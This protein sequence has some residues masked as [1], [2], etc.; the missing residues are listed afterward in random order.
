MTTVK[1]LLTNHFRCPD[2]PIEFDRSIAPG[3]RAGYFQF[4]KG[5]TCYGQLDAA[6]SAEEVTEPLH[7][8]STD[9]RL[10][11]SGCTLPFDP[12]QV[13]DNL[14]RE[15]YVPRTKAHT[16]G[17][18]VDTLVRRTYYAVRPLLPVALRKHLQR[19]FL[20][21]RMETPFP[22]WPIDRTVDRLLERL[23]ALT[24]RAQGLERI[25]FIWFWPEGYL[26]SAI[27][28][29]DVETS[30]GVAFCSELMD[31]D[32]RHGIKSSFQFVPE[33]RYAIPFSLLND[34]RTRGFEINVHDFNHDGKLYWE[35]AEFLRRAAKINQDARKFDAKGFRAGVLYRNPDW[36]DAFDFS[37]DMSFPNVGHL[38]PQPG[39]CCTVMP[40]FIGRILELP[41]T[42]IQ[43]YSLFHVLGEYSIDL[44]KRQ[45]DLIRE[46]HGLISVIT[47]P[48]YLIEPRARSTYMA[49]LEH[50]SYL[51]AEARVWIALPGE[52]DDWWRARSQMKLVQ[53]N[54]VWRIEG[55]GKERARIAYA[56]LVG[57]GIRY[58]IAA[59]SG[60]PS[61]PVNL[62][63]QESHER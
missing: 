46:G 57:D 50:L 23:L 18:G 28:T 49:L 19:A 42:T 21:G 32:D 6:T 51:R 12:V 40:Y 2:T 60:A 55:R 35:R 34:I 47:H 33:E 14:H 15:R 5:V 24:L 1:Q 25:P 11:P 9:V 31:L 27:M 62:I 4:G 7:D 13:V 53:E 36:Y 22:G 63:T 45:I 20:A 44:W 16:G 52:V 37:Y 43:D 41:V 26:S 38:D 29:H 8:A 3:S 10:G 59:D 39:G 58:T 48:D 61:T 17:H 30:E 54:G 56:T